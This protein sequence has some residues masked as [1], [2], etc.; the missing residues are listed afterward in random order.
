MEKAGCEGDSITNLNLAGTSI[1]VEGLKLLGW[2]DE[3]LLSLNLRTVA[4]REGAAGKV[5]IF[6]PRC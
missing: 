2:L 1:S 6:H 3:S 4:T 5:A